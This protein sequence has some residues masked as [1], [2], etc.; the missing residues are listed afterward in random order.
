[1]KNFLITLSIIFIVISANA[2]K[3]TNNRWFIGGE[4]GLSVKSIDENH[5]SEEVFIIRNNTIVGFAFAPKVGYYFN[6]KFALGLSIYSG[7]NFELQKTDNDHY[8]WYSINWGFNPFVRYTAFT[9]KK[10]S[11][12][13]EGRTGVG[14]KHSFDKLKNGTRMSRGNTLAIGVFNITPI[15]GF[16]LTN[17]LQIEAGLHFLNIGYNIDIIEH[18]DIMYNVENV[19]ATRHDFNI[20][21]NSSSILVMS[22][23][24]FGVIYKF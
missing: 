21:F 24:R 1:M 13:L 16:N 18:K 9:Y 10:F 8:K 14:G 17:H 7:I 4:I 11:L 20:G 2:Q 3:D 6:E 22:Q 15:L 12:I 19:N 23:L 5:A